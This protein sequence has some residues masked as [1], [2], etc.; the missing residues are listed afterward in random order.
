MNTATKSK[1]FGAVAA[2]L[3][4]TGGLVVG[5]ASAANADYPAAPTVSVKITITTTFHAG[6]ATT[7]KVKT[8]KGAKITITYGASK[9]KASKKLSSTTVKKTGTT[10]SKV[11]IKTKGTYF[12]KIV[13]KKAGK[14]TKTTYYKVKVK[15]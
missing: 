15:K 12:V 3:V 11:K 7:V 9:S 10:S 1:R 4:L 14:A 13:V 6:Q 8:V 2:A 5:S